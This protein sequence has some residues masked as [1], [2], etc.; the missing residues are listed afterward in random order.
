MVGKWG[1]RWLG[2]A[3]AYFH[4]LPVKTGQNV[5]D[6]VSTNPYKENPKSS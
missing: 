4:D 5:R 1:P 3:L 6:F 2:V